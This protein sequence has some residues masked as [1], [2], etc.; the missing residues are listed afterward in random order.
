[1][2]SAIQPSRRA[3]AEPSRRPGIFFEQGIAAVTRTRTRWYSHR[4]SLMYFF[5]IGAQGQETSF[6][7]P[8]GAPSECRIG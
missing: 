5:S 4:K 1:M 7:P 8:Q 6:A 2:C 3:M